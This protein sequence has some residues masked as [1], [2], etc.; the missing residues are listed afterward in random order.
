MIK[1]YLPVDKAMTVYEDKLTFQGSNDGSTW[2]DYHTADGNVHTGWNYVSWD[3]NKPKHRYFRFKG[4]GSNACVINEAELH[5][6]EAIDSSD[7]TY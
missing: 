6:V 7:T 1:Y 3:S 5:G 2:T 4:S